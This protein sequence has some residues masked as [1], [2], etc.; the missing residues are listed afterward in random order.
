MSI[1]GT[2][3]WSRG[4]IRLKLYSQ[5]VVAAIWAIRRAFG[6]NHGAAD[7]SAHDGVVKLLCN[8]REKL[9][10]VSNV[11]VGSIFVRRESEQDC[12]LAVLVV[13]APKAW[14]NVEADCR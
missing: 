4:K 2:C 7:L 13:D 12:V 6:R 8:E 5:R 3:K 14:W 11:I 10:I 1:N 9:I